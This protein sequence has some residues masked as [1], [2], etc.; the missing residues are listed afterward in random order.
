MSK[1][2]NFTH[3]LYHRQEIKLKRGCV[4]CIMGNEVLFSA[5]FVKPTCNKWIAF[6][7]LVFVFVNRAKRVDQSEL[8]ARRLP[9][10]A[11]VCRRVLEV[12]SGMTSGVCVESDLSSMLQRSS[13]PSH[14][15]PNHHGGQGQVSCRSTF[16]VWNTFWCW[17]AP[18]DQRKPFILVTWQWKGEY[19]TFRKSSYECYLLHLTQHFYLVPQLWGSSIEMLTMT[20]T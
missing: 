12:M 1:K 19:R 4:S 6:V 17:R 18:V 14:H 5:T 3:K 11:S 2:K 8:A 10:W 16:N 9:S 13:A 7:I 15:H 20:A